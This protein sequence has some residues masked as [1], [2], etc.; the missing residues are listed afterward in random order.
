MVEHK[1][2]IKLYNYFIQNCNLYL[3]LEPALDGH[4]DKYIKVNFIFE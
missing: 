4:L 1:N 2:I 3:I